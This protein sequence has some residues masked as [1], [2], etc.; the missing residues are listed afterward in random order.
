MSSTHLPPKSQ[1]SASRPRSK[2]RSTESVKR[3]R[4]RIGNQSNAIQII[5]MSQGNPLKAIS[6]FVE[7]SIDAKAT[8][9]TLVRGKEAGDHYLRIIDDGAGVRHN[10]EG[11]P[12]FEYVATHICDSIKRRLK[13]EGAGK[14]LQGEFG[15]GLLSFWSVGDNLTMRSLDREQRPWQLQM[16]K[17]SQKYEIIRSRTLLGQPGTELDIRPL[18]TSIRSLSAEKIQT[19]LGAEL[20]NRLLESG[21]RIKIQDRTARTELDIVPRLFEGRR[22]ELPAVGCPVEIFVN[23]ASKENRVALYRNGTRVLESLTELDEFTQS[24]WNSGFFQGYI[25]A[26]ELQLTPGTRTGIIRD[27]AFEGFVE[28]VKQLSPFLDEE[29]KRLQQAQEEKASRETL[30]ALQKAFREGFQGLPDEDYDWFE[31]DDP[32]RVS[33]KS[34]GAD[35]GFGPGFGP[36][37]VAGK[38]TD[39]PAPDTGAEDVRE[40]DLFSRVS[41]GIP[42]DE[43]QDVL[44]SGDINAPA[45]KAFFEFSGP[46]HSVRISPVSSLVA[47]GRT[48]SLR[49]AARDKNGRDVT[50][51]LT[52]EWRILE[53]E[54]GLQGR[55]GLDSPPGEF[56]EFH[57][58]AEPG[59][60]KVQVRVMQGEIIKETT[61]VVTVTESLGAREGKGAGRDGGRRGRGL[62]EYTFL[63]APAEPWRSKFDHERNLILVNNGHRDFLFASRVQALKLRYI[64]RLFSKELV[65]ANFP[66]EEPGVLLERLVEVSLHV[67]EKLK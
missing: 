24:V 28:I 37:P 6:E 21:V 31:I 15:I 48:K 29:V 3:G 55:E 33:R 58:P 40:H 2:D 54:G 32:R 53:G 63:R 7:N 45:Q 57:A 16:S 47:V 66:G 39:E 5:A 19:Y 10:P 26:P 1:K 14:G 30:Q 8:R 22:L 49:A 42:R 17:G 51:R 67:E 34:A 44:E 27:A 20:R 62:P 41:G 52:F 11:I 56:A 13:V 23:E 61:A 25:D 46:L 36:R 4:L 59:I 12:D 60:C 35:S 64:C 38:G 65:I 9:V 43:G 50:E 18:N